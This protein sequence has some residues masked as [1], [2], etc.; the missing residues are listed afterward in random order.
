[1]QNGLWREEMDRA[2]EA[3]LEA[4]VSLEPPVPVSQALVLLVLVLLVLVLLV[5]R[6]LRPREESEV[7]L[8]R[9]VLVPESLAVPVGRGGVFHRSFCRSGS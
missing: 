3:T 4:P 5:L 8:V 1:M 2:E 6:V 9:P 7:C